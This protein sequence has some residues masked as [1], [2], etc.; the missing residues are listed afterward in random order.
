MEKKI[1]VYVAG[2][3]NDD[4]VGYIKN[5]HRMIK[6]ARKVREAGY[7]VYVPCNDVL[8]GFVDGNFD[9]HEYFDNSQPWLMSA[10]AVFLVQGWESST[11]TRREMETA[12]AN[13]IP[14]FDSIEKMDEHF[15]T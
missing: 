2:K 12:D 1:K 6:T 13:N 8:E 3:L 9:Y 14:I 7:C 10:D 11:G 5:V 4:A 15:K